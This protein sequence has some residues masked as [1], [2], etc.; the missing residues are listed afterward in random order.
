MPLAGAPAA[1]QLD[2]SPE[3]FQ[4]IDAN[5]AGRNVFSFIRRGSDAPDLACVVNFSGAPHHG[6][7]IG[8]PRGGYWREVLNSDAEG[9]GLAI[10]EAHRGSITAES[11]AGRTTFRIVVPT[12]GAPAP[13]PEATHCPPQPSSMR[14]L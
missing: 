9:Y 6:Y 10:V 3:G 2:G 4:W 8:L 11:T 1:W 5:D 13:G 12:T 14:W 7:R